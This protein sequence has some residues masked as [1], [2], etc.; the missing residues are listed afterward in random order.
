MGREMNRDSKKKR[1]KIVDFRFFQTDSNNL[2]E[3]IQNQTSKGWKVKQK[4][5][6]TRKETNVSIWK[7]ARG[8]DDH[9]RNGNSIRIFYENIS[10][11]YFRRSANNKR[12]EGDWQIEGGRVDGI[13]E[14]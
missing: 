8:W 4:V 5:K 7:S 12:I 13:G 2:L 14:G 6:V 3:E 10:M 1:E 11:I 9:F